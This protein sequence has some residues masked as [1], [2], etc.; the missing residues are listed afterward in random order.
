MAR[1]KL[2][3]K[4]VGKDQRDAQKRVKANTRPIARMTTGKRSAG[5]RAR[6]RRHCSGIDSPLTTPPSSPIPTSESFPKEVAAEQ[7]Q[8]VSYAHNRVSTNFLI[9]YFIDIFL[10]IVLLFLSGWRHF[11]LLQPMPKDGVLGMHYSASTIRG[12]RLSR[13]RFFLLSGMP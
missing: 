5:G 10:P 9:A 11:I 12:G 7:L 13:R 3:A 2:T 1:T 8:R 6:R 4:K